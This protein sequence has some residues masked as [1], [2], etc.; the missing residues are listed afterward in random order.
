ME[1]FRKLFPDR[2]KKGSTVDA[3]QSMIDLFSSDLHHDDSFRSHQPHIDRS[4]SL[5]DD[6]LHHPTERADSFSDLTSIIA[7]K[8]NIVSVFNT[9]RKT[10]FLDELKEIL[11]EQGLQISEI[12]SPHKKSL[13]SPSIMKVQQ[14]DFDAYV[15]KIQ[16]VYDIYKKHN[17][18]RLKKLKNKEQVNITGSLMKCYEAVP[19]QYFEKDFS[20]DFQY[21]TRDK[22][23]LFQIQEDLG[24]YLDHVELNL[25]YQITSRFQEF[26]DVILKLNQMEAQI[27][28]CLYSIKFFRNFNKEL[29]TKCSDKVQNVL[30]LKRRKINIEKTLALLEIINVVQNTLPTLIHLIQ[31]NNFRYA[32]ELVKSSEE[33]YKNKL[34]PI[35]ALKNFHVNFNEARTTLEKMLTN[36][37]EERCINYLTPAFSYNKTNNTPNLADVSISMMEESFMNISVAELTNDDKPGT[38]AALYWTLNEFKKNDQ[39][40]INIAKIVLEYIK[41]KDFPLTVYKGKLLEVMKKFHK[42]FL[43][44]MNEYIDNL[45]KEDKSNVD[46]STLFDLHIK[47]ILFYFELF[48]RFISRHFDLVHR[49]LETL[50]DHYD[51]NFAEKVSLNSDVSDLPLLDT[52]AMKNLN[53]TVNEFYLTLG[54]IFKYFNDKMS[55]IINSFKMENINITQFSK[56]VAIFEEITNYFQN[57]MRLE[58]RI[59]SWIVTEKDSIRKPLLRV[60]SNLTDKIT[61]SPLQNLR[62]DCE[63]N[64]IGLFHKQKIELLRQSLEQESWTPADIEYTYSLYF[65][66]FVE[67]DNDLEKHPERLETT[68]DILK[69]SRPDVNDLEIVKHLATE[70]ETADSSRDSR[71]TQD[72]IKSHQNGEMVSIQK[73]ELYINKKRYRVTGSFLLLIQICYEYFTIASKFNYIGMDTIGKLFEIIK[74]YNSYTTQLVLGAGAIAFGKI[75]KITAKVLALSTISLTLLVD[76]VPPLQTK[77]EKKIKLT[78]ENREKVSEQAKKVRQDLVDHANEIA[79]KIREILKSKLVEQCN[80]LKKINWA[81]TQDKINIPTKSSA[82][83]LNSIRQMYKLIEDILFREHLLSIFSAVFTDIKQNFVPIFENLNVESKTAAKRIKE[84]LKYFTEDLYQIEIFQDPELKYSDFEGR[85]LS[86]IQDKCSHYLEITSIN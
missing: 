13:I 42:Q 20:F 46:A 85:I 79:S 83:I 72:T 65:S 58:E 3:N 1:Y 10:T 43:N 67:P 63:K 44:D 36:E 74:L 4:F 33:T 32:V 71:R 18:S 52:K 23:K 31:T 45:I 12:I 57:Q 41:I 81:S 59:N 68:E 34:K 26:L 25:Y 14:K 47:F 86:I 61:I 51:K 11:E 16:K 22:E 49:V 54:M 64:F 19:Q 53:E 70:D 55:E 28:N 5:P 62:I 38:S 76:L 35:K 37:F 17:A 82:S 6:D 48:K 9:P 84:E 15:R 73:N 77:L 60:V 21:F 27:Q 8:T 78:N 30:R 39:T 66:F 24:E 50:V 75:K 40:E 80:E 7:P 2:K 69:S 56:L 29:K